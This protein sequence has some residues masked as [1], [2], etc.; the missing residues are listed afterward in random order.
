MQQLNED[1]YL[2][3]KKTMVCKEPG[4]SRQV[5]IPNLRILIWSQLTSLQTTAVNPRQPTLKE[6]SDYPW[7]HGPA[8][9]HV[10]WK[11]HEDQYLFDAMVIGK[12]YA[13]ISSH[14]SRGLIK[15]S[16]DA[17]R[18]RVEYHKTWEDSGHLLPKQ[19]DWT[20]E[21]VYQHRLEQHRQ[22]TELTLEEYEEIVLFKGRGMRGLNPGKFCDQRSADRLRKELQK[23]DDLNPRLFRT[24]VAVLQKRPKES[25]PKREERGRQRAAAMQRLTK[26]RP[27]SNERIRAVDRQIISARNGGMSLE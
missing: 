21:E 8:G 12:N 5:C 18:A 23:L 16:Q 24:A 25:G 4:Q 7:L 17:C 20:E 1:S 22:D 26:C 15:R 19:W 3:P 14:L 27:V 11:A 6:T 2:G 13:Q 10:P 9:E